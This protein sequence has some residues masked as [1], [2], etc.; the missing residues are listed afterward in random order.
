MAAHFLIPGLQ[1]EDSHIFGI[2]LPRK[3]VACKVGI[4]ISVLQVRKLR[5]TK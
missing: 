2:L 3:N 5:P 1:I 4:F